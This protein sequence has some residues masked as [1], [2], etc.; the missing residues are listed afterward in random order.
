MFIKLV[1][2]RYLCKEKASLTFHKIG[3]KTH[4]KYLRLI[5]KIL[6]RNIRCHVKIRHNKNK[7]WLFKTSN[8]ICTLTPFIYELFWLKW[9]I[10][11][12]I[13][14]QIELNIILRIVILCQCR[15][16]TGYLLLK[17]RFYFVLIFYSFTISFC[18]VSFE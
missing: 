4:S 9:R 15:H 13:W 2:L 5:S 12:N 7:L 14:M 17:F 3:Y 8:E 1:F 11:W 16:D 18:I 6:F 10:E